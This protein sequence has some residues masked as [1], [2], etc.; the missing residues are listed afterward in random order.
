MKKQLVVVNPALEEKHRRLIGSAAE[1]HGYSVLF[2]AEAESA[3]PALREAEIVFGQSPFL[4]QNSPALRWLC[5]PSAGT[6]QFTK[7]MFASPEARLTNSS[8]AYGVTISEHVIMTALEILRRQPEYNRI[9]ESRGWNRGLAVRSLH[10]SRITLLGTG[11]IGKETA[12]RLRGFRP[13]V[14]TG[15][16]RSGKNPDGLFD[17]ILSPRELAELLPETDILIISLPATAETNKMLD[18]AG[19]ALLPDGALIINVGRGSVIDQ[20]ALEKELRAGR[21]F[22]ALDVFEKEPLPKEDSLW[23]C[24]NLL[25]TPHIAGNMTL[26]WTKDR[27]VDLFLEDFENYC[28]GKPLL[29]QVI[30]S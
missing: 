20:Q 12:L 30:P 2:F 28:A 24:P 8:G 18:A 9:V 17:R 15:V 14:L 21:L 7:E 16:N 29:R 27:I 23:T 5:S 6:D 19:L 13:A 22:A 25:I 10:G 3:L 4:A 1:K 11:D 26:P